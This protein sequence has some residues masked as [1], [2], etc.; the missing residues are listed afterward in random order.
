MCGIVGFIDF[1]HQNPGESLPGIIAQMANTLAH[2][3][4]D[5]EGIWIDN[6]I[7]IALGHRRLAIQDLSPEGHQP[8]VSSCGRYVI[9]FNGEI[10]NFLEL[11]KKMEALGHSFRGHS[12]TEI[13]L[14]AFSQWG[15]RNAVEH[16][17]GM[18]A[19][20]LWDRQKQVLHLTRDRLGEKPLYW[21]WMGQTFVFASE[22]K[23]LRKYPQWQENVDPDSVA[24]LMQY[25]YIPAPYCIYRNMQKLLPGH[26]LSILDD[27][28]IKC[29]AYWSM[30][31]V[32]EQGIANPFSGSATEA[33]EHLD[34]ILKDTISHQMLADVPL[35]AFLSGG[36]DSSL[37]V[38]IM[39]SLNSQPVQT[40][41]IGFHEKD[42][43]EANQAKSIAQY[44]GTDHTELYVTSAEALSAIP[45]LPTLYDEPFADASQIPTFLVAQLTKRH[46]TVSLSGDGGDE[47]F[48]GYSRYFWGELIWRRI[49]WLPQN[50]RD[51]VA[52]SLVTVS[53]ERWNTIFQFLEKQLPP[54]WQQRMPGDKLHKLAG[55][56]ASDSAEDMYHG[57][58]SHWKQPENLVLGVSKYQSILTKIKNWPHVSNFIQRMMLLDTLSYLPDDLLVKVDR[59]S[60]GVSLETRIP[61][62]D[63]RIVEFAW[64]VPMS[65]KVHQQEGKLLL[66][67]L[68]Y[69]YVPRHLMD[70]PKA[71][72][73]IPIAQWLRGPLREWAEELLDQRRLQQ[74]GTFNA[75]LVHQKWSEHLEGSRNW[76][77]SLWNVLMFQAWLEQ[78]KNSTHSIQ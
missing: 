19:F 68:L 26:V 43:N 40:F 50:L 59:A 63:H 57:L 74:E 69:K 27:G 16:F 3:G 22:L 65:M 75:A 46:V 44:L 28:E 72:F 5:D 36:I 67:Q 31:T 32:A 70:R 12:D 52:Q 9:I 76:H 18:F 60:M 20:A 2:R 41:T 10:Y 35:G 37:I 64:Q 54:N 66:K 29:R 55:V 23:A 58:V 8:M 49:S 1:S 15:Y 51:F 13:M 56:L 42:Y 14:S 21:G 39:Q 62:L 47:L 11:K 34:W 4:P 7:G 77:S 48:A 45:S 25:N 38:A 24:L 71:G 61:F 53:P 17:V 78:T 30:E 6:K 73:A 33:V